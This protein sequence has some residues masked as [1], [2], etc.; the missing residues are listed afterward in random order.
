MEQSQAASGDKLDALRKLLLA[1]DRRYVK[2]THAQVKALEAAVKTQSIDEISVGKVLASAIAQ[3]SEKDGR[4]K[5]A[6]QPLFESQAYDSCR[7]NTENMAEALFPVIGPATRKLLLNLFKPKRRGSSYSIEQLFLIDNSSGLPIAHVARNAD[8]QADIDLVSSMLS[9]IE[10]Y[11]Q[12]AF[13]THSFEGLEQIQMGELTILLEW[14]PKATLA[15]VIQGVGPVSLLTRLQKAIEDIHKDFDAFLKDYKGESTH[16]VQL[17]EARLSRVL[18]MQPSGLVNA[19]RSYGKLALIWLTLVCGIAYLVLDHLGDLRFNRVVSNID[20]RPG[21]V[22]VESNRRLG[23]DFIRGLVDV[24]ASPLESRIEGVHTSRL[25]LHWTKI[26]MRDDSETLKRLQQVVDAEQGVEL[27]ISNNT[28]IVSGDPTLSW[29]SQLENLLPL[30]TSVTSIE[31][32]SALS[33][34]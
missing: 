9:A 17:I 32:Q 11:V 22:V 24:N 13:R 7:H 21:Y 28:L 8:A 20:A 18:A 19:A 10:S 29:M 6:F 31:Y 12:E 3:Q 1:Q 2:R 5:R 25:K 4:L 15:T 34:D 30:L 23:E 16:E 27:A 14:G 26:S 33:S